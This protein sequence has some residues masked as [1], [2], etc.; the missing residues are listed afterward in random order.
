MVNRGLNK[1]LI[2]VGISGN[3]VT[4]LS[5]RVQW[6]VL[7][8]SPSKVFVYIGINDLW[9][10][11]SDQFKLNYDD[12]IQ[13]LQTIDTEIILVAPA[14]IG[15]KKNNGNPNDQKLNEFAQIVGDL[16]MEHSL[17]WINLRQLC[18]DYLKENNPNNLSSGILTTDGIHMN[19]QG[20]AF[21][22]RIF[23]AF[24]INQ[25]I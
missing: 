1:D 14:L 7:E 23:E 4:D 24:L 5:D 13:T 20:N 10:V 16:A 11:K 2:G 22:A 3:T 21:L 12:F 15:E 17:E 8:A 6:D 18:I 9:E 19:Q 25:E